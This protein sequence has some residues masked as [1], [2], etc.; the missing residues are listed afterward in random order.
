[1]C[2]ENQAIFSNLSEFWNN[3]DINFRNEFFPKSLLKYLDEQLKDT[4]KDFLDKLRFLQN[5]FK[6]FSKMSS[7]LILNKRQMLEKRNNFY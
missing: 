6:M 2:H 5:D 1:M 4:F 3:K 7:T